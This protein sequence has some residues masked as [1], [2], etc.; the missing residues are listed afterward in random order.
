[1]AVIDE[2]TVNGVRVRICDD[3]LIPSGT[4]E[5]HRTVERQ[6][7]VAYDILRGWV[8]KNGGKETGNCD[9]DGG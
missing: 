5:W 4:P 7:R 1:M 3:C 6:R 2:R 9:D 8:E